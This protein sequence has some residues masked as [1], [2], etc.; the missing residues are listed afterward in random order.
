V[1]ERDPSDKSATAASGGARAEFLALVQHSLDAGDFV[2]L[3]LARPHERES[4]GPRRIAVRALALRGRPGLSFVE[5]HATRDVTRNT[6]VAQGIGEI[7]RLLGPA[8]AHAHLQTTAG[9][10]ELRR[11]KRGTWGMSRRTAHRA[12]PAH[13]P[14]ASAVA[15]GDDGDLPAGAPTHDRIKRRHVDIGRPWL[16]DLGVTDADHRL[17][18]A[19]ARKW[20]QIDKFVEIFDHA[21]ASSLLRERPDVRVVDFGAGKG[22]LTFA[23]HDHLVRT[24]G[25]RADVTGVELRSD[26]VE[27]AQRAAVRARMEGLTFVQGDVRSQAAPAMDVMIA[28]H[29][30]DTATDHALH[31]GVR[32]GAQV[33]L[34]AP[35]CH[36]ELRPQILPPALLKPLLQHGIHL[37][38]Q[39]EMVTDGLRALLLEAEGY[40]TQVF[41]FVSLEHTSKNKMILAVRRAAPRDRA[42]TLGQ[43]Q[44]LKDFYGVREQA[45]ERLLRDVPAAR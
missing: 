34:A 41:E 29:A 36:K 27:L 40:A 38:Q 13:E 11:S 44:A 30:C 22:Y 16:V 35:C 32:A 42:A 6:D 7:D 15:A 19:M 21:I 17:I 2:R 24:L 3:V 5:S 39:A 26:L 8:F 33:I 4:P 18:P 25:K 28:L 43:V 31:L 45:L 14:E 9:E 23:V 37:G 1:G 10:A 12:A 20:K